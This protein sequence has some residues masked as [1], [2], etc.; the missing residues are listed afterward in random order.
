M[1]P[2]RTNAKEDTPKPK[3]WYKRLFCNHKII[4]KDC[5]GW[6]YGGEDCLWHDYV[7]NSKCV[8]CGLKSSRRTNKKRIWFFDKC[9]YP[10]IVKDIKPPKRGFR[11]AG[12]R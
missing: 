4:L 2:Y 12:K 6:S 10:D 9:E 8:R 5:I 1:G 11:P 7:F 3:A